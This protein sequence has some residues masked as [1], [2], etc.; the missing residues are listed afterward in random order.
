MWH[1]IVAFRRF[2]GRWVIGARATRR[3]PRLG[4][5]GAFGLV[6]VVALVVDHEVDHGPFRQRRGRVES[7]SAVLHERAKC[8]GFVL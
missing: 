7:A 6:E 8:R 1:E 2:R 4:Q 3:A 5:C